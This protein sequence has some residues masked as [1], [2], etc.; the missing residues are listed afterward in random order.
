MPLR[1]SSDGIIAIA[2][3]HPRRDKAVQ[4]DPSAE[5]EIG[6]KLFGSND[7]GSFVIAITSTST[8]MPGHAS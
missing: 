6:R 1:D 7:Y 3:I 4:G 5:M 8:I 2:A